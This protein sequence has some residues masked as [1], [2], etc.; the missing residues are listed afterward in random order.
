MEGA[1]D[2]AEDGAEDGVDDAQVGEAPVED[3]TAGTALT[4]AV[5]TAVAAGAWVATGSTTGFL[6]GVCELVLLLASGY[7]AYLLVVFTLVVVAFRLFDRAGTVRP[8][9]FTDRFPL[10]FWI[11]SVVVVASAT[12]TSWLSGYDASE[13]NWTVGS[14][15]AAVLVLAFATVRPRRTRDDHG[16]GGPEEP[17]H[18][19]R[20]GGS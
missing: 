10:T 3:D 20:E 18:R 2:G 15:A 8:E 1:D 5:C 17:R 11:T 4:V 9:R 13:W 7:L 16:P 19:R 14:A 12:L 6:R